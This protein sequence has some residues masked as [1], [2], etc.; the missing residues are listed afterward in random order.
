[1]TEKERVH[2][3]LLDLHTEAVALVAEKFTV[4]ERWGTDADKE[5]WE[6]ACWQED[7]IWDAASTWDAFGDK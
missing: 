1:M 6:R 7:A 2:M 3:F 5:E 4:Y